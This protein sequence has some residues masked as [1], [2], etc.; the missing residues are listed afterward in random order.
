MSL[1][2]IYKKGLLEFPDKI[3]FI[4]GNDYCTYQELDQN[5]KRYTRTLSALGVKKGDRVGMLMPNCPELVYAYF[6]CFRIGAMAVPSSC[7]C[8]TPEIVFHTNH[9]QV[10]IYLVHQ[11]LEHVVYDLQKEVSSIKSVFVINPD[12]KRRLPSFSEQLDLHGESGFV[13]DFEPDDDYPALVIYTSGST[14]KPKG[15]THT[16]GSLYNAAVNRCVTLGHTFADSFLTTSYV[17]HGA[18]PT[19]VFLPMFLIGGTA[20]FLSH[21]STMNFLD[22]LVNHCPTFAAAAPGQWKD[23]IDL[24]ESKGKDFSFLKY[25]TSGG[26][27]VPFQLLMNFHELTG[28]DLT[29][30]LGMTECG[31]YITFPPEAKKIKGSLGKPI[32]NTEVR[33]VDYNGNDVPAGEQGEI[34][35]R[36]N[37]VMKE[38][39]NDPVNTKRSFTNEWFHTGDVG[40]FDNDG[41]I[42]FCGR[43]KDIIIVGGGNVAPGE[44]ESALNLHPLIEQSIVVG[45]PDELTEQA[46]FAFIRLKNNAEK[47]SEQELTDYANA[48]LAEYKVPKYWHFSDSF[49]ASGIADK[50]DRKKLAAEALNYID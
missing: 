9:C 47:P 30:S 6:A 41:N 21:Y 40:K 4:C 27:V 12:E 7:Y 22:M 19:I 28:V 3:A 8:K 15:V 50:I 23:L 36:S 24:P 35:V 18:A 32:H 10:K 42:F 34:I 29:A 39:W 46:V 37:S 14:G 1:V 38:Y 31:G 33:L 16:H 48:N 25:A 11:E 2:E 43:I 17:C 5:I 26:S 45:V 49:E 20:I 13:E 44:V